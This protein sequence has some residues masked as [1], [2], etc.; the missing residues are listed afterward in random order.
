MIAD[1]LI[2]RLLLDFQFVEQWIGKETQ[3]FTDKMTSLVLKPTTAFTAK[4]NGITKAV[5]KEVTQSC[6]SDVEKVNKFMKVNFS[7]P[8]NVVMAGHEQP[9]VTGENLRDL[10]DEC[11]KM[12]NT[13]KENVYF[14]QALNAELAGYENLNHVFEEGNY[15][16]QKAE[17][18]IQSNVDLEVLNSAAKKINEII[19]E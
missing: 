14:A 5:C 6:I 2:S 4:I 15:C 7:I 8:D 12:E 11:A 19:Y 9:D 17:E 13:V 10:E 3:R 1:F 18:F 16:I